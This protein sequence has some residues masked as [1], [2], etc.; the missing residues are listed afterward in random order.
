MF[1]TRYIATIQ[2][3]FTITQSLLEAGVHNLR[4]K[5]ISRNIADP[6]KT[7]IARVA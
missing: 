5:V 7:G 4:V 1:H 6:L 3:V 2:L